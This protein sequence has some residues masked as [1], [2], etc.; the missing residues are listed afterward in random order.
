MLVF[1][2]A[3]LP[4]GS[5]LVL[6]IVR[7]PASGW[8]ILFGWLCTLVLVLTLAG[9]TR[10]YW[11]YG[12]CALGGYGVAGLACAPKAVKSNETV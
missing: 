3:V 4:L 1:A 11:V 12:L 7:T 6:W 9:G 10:Q 5:W 2:L 8:V